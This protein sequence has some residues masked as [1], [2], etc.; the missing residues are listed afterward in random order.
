MG[1]VFRNLVLLSILTLSWT[2]DGL[3][4]GIG[5]RFQFA[6]ELSFVYSLI[7]DSGSDASDQGCVLTTNPDITGTSG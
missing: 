2:T 3:S 6:K 5:E 7:T 4:V 1:L